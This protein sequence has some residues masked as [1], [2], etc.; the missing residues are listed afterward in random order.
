MHPALAYT[1]NTLDVSNM[2]AHL[3]APLA[4]LISALN[5]D[6]A[7]E[8]IPECTPA[9]SANCA[10]AAYKFSLE[11]SRVAVTRKL[12]ALLTSLPVEPQD[13]INLPSKQAME[14]LHKSWV[15]Y[16][17]SYCGDYYWYVWPGA[18]TWKSAESISCT[19]DAYKKYAAF[20][21][22]IQSCVGKDQECHLVACTPFDCSKK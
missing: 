9:E 12:K 16:V 6:A 20:L 13:R 10:G 11:Q 18:S 19:S 1:Y 4:I 2:Q 21:D 22:Q 14:K 8:E 3:I 5:F 15:G 7:S 17:A